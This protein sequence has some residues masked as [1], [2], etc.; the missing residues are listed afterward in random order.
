[1]LLSADLKPIGPAILYK[2]SL[3]AKKSSEAAPKASEVKVEETAEVED[4]DEDDLNE[5]LNEDE[6]IAPPDIE[7]NFSESPAIRSLSTNCL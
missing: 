3:A 7:G 6:E 5:P 2:D 1:M 4:E